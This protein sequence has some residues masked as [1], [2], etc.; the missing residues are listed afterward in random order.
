MKIQNK[1]YKEIFLNLIIAN[2]GE[3]VPTKSL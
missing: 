2:D 3:M 1:I